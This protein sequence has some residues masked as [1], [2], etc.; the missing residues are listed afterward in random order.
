MIL[1]DRG[2]EVAPRDDVPVIIG[3]LMEKLG[4]TE[5]ELSM[6]DLMNY[7]G[8]LYYDYDVMS[9]IYTIRFRKET[10]DAQPA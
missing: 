1:S 2:V 8:R 7:E 4:I 10:E 9:G 3:M 6:I 5:F